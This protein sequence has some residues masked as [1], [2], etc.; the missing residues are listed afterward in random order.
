M[1]KYKRFF[2]KSQNNRSWDCRLHFG[3][4][5]ARGDIRYIVLKYYFLIY[6]MIPELAK[7]EGPNSHCQ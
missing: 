5:I 2:K 1:C 4:T 6:E 7:N 3:A